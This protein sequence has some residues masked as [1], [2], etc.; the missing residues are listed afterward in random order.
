VR[1]QVAVV[2]A[3]TAACLLWVLWGI[4]FAQA[5]QALSDF[6]WATVVGVEAVYL[7]THLLRVVRFRL[8]LGRPLPFWPLF[9]L[10]SVGYLAIHTVPLRMGEFVR[11]Y[12]LRERH[13]VTF[14]EGLAAI[15]VERLVDLI[16]LLGMILLTTVLVEV[17]EGRL[18]VQGLD[19][20]AAGQRTVGAMVAVGLLGLVVLVLMPDALL[21]RLSR[22]PGGGLLRRFREGL[23]HLLR[24]PASAAQILAHSV[25]IW[26]GTVWAIQLT[27]A[28]FPGMSA[29]LGVALAAWAATLAGTTAVPTPGFFGAFE[30]F[31][32]GTI[33]VFGAEEAAAV[34][35]A[36]LVHLCQFGFTVVT[37]GISL[38]VEG[39]S[40]REVVARSRAESA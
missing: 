35:C 5:G 37:G 4:D 8:I 16:M 25:I 23:L 36:V 22:L 33:R 26:A 3:V 29:D 31:F 19:V 40:L 9:R 15:F 6:H 2:L 32:S 12:L 10:V 24:A 34:A 21:D 18:V 30:A 20:L 17:P 1:I 14:G 7:G 39:V 27:L 13:A 28:A 11:P 38:F